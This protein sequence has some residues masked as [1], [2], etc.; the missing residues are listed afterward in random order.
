[1]SSAIYN[2]IDAPKDCF[3]FL[4]LHALSNIDLRPLRE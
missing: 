2:G 4:N 1:M 3:N